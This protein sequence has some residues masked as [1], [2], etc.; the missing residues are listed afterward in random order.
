MDRRQR[1]EGLINF[2]RTIQRPDRPIEELDDHQR[3][4]ESGLIDSLAIL[5]IV[6]YLEQTYNIDFRD[7]GV[8]P[9]DLGSV[10]AILDLIER[11]TL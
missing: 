4:V 11:E 10:S 9:S 3:L 7:R 6:L 5:Q 1:K 2:L 8:D